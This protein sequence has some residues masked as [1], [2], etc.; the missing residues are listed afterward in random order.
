MKINI[1][2][3]FIFAAALLLV[4]VVQAQ[5]TIG[6]QAKIVP[7]AEVD[8]QSAFVDAERERI[9]GHLDKAVGLYKKFVYDNPD[10]GAAWYGLSRAYFA[11]NDLANATD[12]IG[13][14]ISAEPDNTWYQIF[15]ADV[16]EKTGR[17][18]DAVKIYENLV[19]R[20]PQTIE[21]LEH[22]AYLQVLAGDPENGL[23]SLDKLEKLTGIEEETSLEKHMIYVGM[24]DDKKAALELRK[25]ADAY[26]ARL[27]YRHRLAAYYDTM[28]DKANAKAV[29]EDILR[30]DPNDKV[31]KL[32][33]L[34]KSKNSTDAEYLETLKPL[35]G[36][37]KI[38]IDAKIKEILPYFPKLDAG[39]D[40]MLTQNLL[41]L[42]VLVE[43]AHADDPKAWS[44][45]GDLFYH[46]N[47][48][49]EALEKY[50]QCIRLS[51]NVFSVW[52]NTLDILQQ[53]KNYGEMLRVAE[54][55]IDAFPNQPKAYYSFGLAAIEKGRYDDAISQLEQAMLMSGNNLSLRLD[56]ADQIGLALL[57]KKDVDTAIAR[58]EQVLQKGGDKHPGILEHY[59]DAL[60]QS[61]QN[62]KALEYWQKANA[63]RKSPALEQKI[64]SGKL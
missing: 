41:D 51:P 55:A 39:N 35:F 38:S 5:N 12:A 24:G 25:L 49:D 14:A 31:A 56:L 6:G 15:Q 32:A 16:Y 58:Y 36:D 2:K 23:R 9:L 28:G 17:T 57:G 37:P 53:Q 4:T 10:N 3:H 44:L 48:L 18:K 59:G 11:Q 40:A 54:Q 46:A 50:R 22:L 63:I 62:R 26:P 64:S 8:R 29:Y 61:G 34:D 60:F 27:E 42:G 21:F 19:K 13:K 43:K 1:L 33:A 52:E 47:R 45:S 7:E 30:R 20:A